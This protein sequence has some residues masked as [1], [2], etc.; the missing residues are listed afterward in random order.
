MGK[1]VKSA[2]WKLNTG[3][4]LLTIITLLVCTIMLSGVLRWSL[5]FL[6]FNVLH[7]YRIYHPLPATFTV[8]RGKGE[9]N[10]KSSE[11]M[12]CYSCYHGKKITAATVLGSCG[13]LSFFLPA[14][15]I[16]FGLDISVPGLDLS[17]MNLSLSQIKIY[18]AH[19]VTQRNHAVPQDFQVPC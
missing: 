5:A 9:K 8:S 19:L 4:F 6:I 18:I 7:A 11:C 15:C 16:A 3:H 14:H 12:W 17:E 1:K 13:S 10:K 2:W